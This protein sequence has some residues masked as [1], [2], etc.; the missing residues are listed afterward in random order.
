M[1]KGP[2]DRGK[3]MESGISLTKILVKANFV[4]TSLCG[5]FANIVPK[6]QLLHL[7]ECVCV[8][9]VCVCARAHM[10]KKE[11]ISV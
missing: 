6:S 4:S 7:T 8:Y 3:G 9:S 5:S 11:K 10:R 2:S 1:P